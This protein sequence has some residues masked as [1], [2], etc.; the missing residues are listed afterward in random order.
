MNTCISTRTNWSLD[1]CCNPGTIHSKLTPKSWNTKQ[2]ISENLLWWWK[3]NHYLSLCFEDNN[4]NVNSEHNME[5]KNNFLVPGLRL[6]RWPIR[7]M[8]VVSEKWEDGSRTEHQRVVFTVS[9]VTASFPR[10]PEIPWPTRYP[11]FS[12]SDYVLCGNLKTLCMRILSVHE[13]IWRNLFAWKSFKST[14]QCRRDW[15][16]NSKFTFRNASTKMGTT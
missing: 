16:P 10:L 9:S 4:G 5:M 8:F 14:E 12:M 6:K 1:K 2:P 11:D 3:N 15:R 13:T 7:Q